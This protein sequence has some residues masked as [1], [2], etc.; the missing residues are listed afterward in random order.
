M[1]SGLFAYGSKIATCPLTSI[2]GILIVLVGVI[3]LW[4]SIGNGVE[5]ENELDK[6]WIEKGGRVQEELDYINKTK[7]DGWTQSTSL[8]LFEAKFSSVATV[9]TSAAMAD[10]LKVLEAV[11]GIVVEVKLEDGSVIPFSFSGYVNEA[12]GKY[13]LCDYVPFPDAIVPSQFSSI[14][15]NYTPCTRVTALDCFREGN[16]DFYLQEYLST[17]QSLN[18]EMIVDQYR[19]LGYDDL[20]SFVGMSNDEIQDA[21][22]DGCE[23]Y[24]RDSMQWDPSLIFGSPKFNS[25]GE[26]TSAQAFQMVVR[27]ASPQQVQTKLPELGLS[28][29]RIEEIQQEWL[30]LLEAK[31]LDLNG[32]LEFLRVEVYAD[33]ALSRVLEEYSSG[34]LLLVSLGYL[35][36]IYFVVFSQFSKRFMNNLILCGLFGVFMVALGNVFSLAVF[37]LLGLKM[38]ATVTQVLPFLALGLGVDDLF[39]FLSVYREVNEN[40]PSMDVKSRIGT[41]L[42]QGGVGIMLTSFCNSVAFGMGALIPI[43]A[44]QI[45]SLASSLAVFV[46]FITLVVSIPA[47]LALQAGMTTP[48]IAP[49]EGPMIVAKEISSSFVTR[50]YIPFLQKK[51]VRI[52]GTILFILVLAVSV[53]LSTMVVNGL[54]ASD[55]VPAESPLARALA[56]RNAHFDSYPSS[57]AT[58]KLDYGDPEI[59]KAMREMVTS[60]KQVDGV[61]I[62][63]SG[64]LDSMINYYCNITND[65]RANCD[66]EGFMDPDSFEDLF[67][68]FVDPTLVTF[69]DAFGYSMQ[70]FG[71]NENGNVTLAL[72]AFDM[73][74][75][76]STSEIVAAIER[77]RGRLS[78]HCGE[79]KVLS[80]CFPNGYVFTLW[81]Q[82]VNL[83]YNF[84]TAFAICEIAVFF[85]CL[86]LVLDPLI[87]LFVSAFSAA[88]VIQIYGGM[89]L[90]DIK[91]SAIP[92]VSLIMSIGIAVEFT[93]H[94]SS[95]FKAA[96]GDRVEKMS[97]AIARMCIPILEG[98]FSSLLGFV[99]LAFS[100][101]D[102]IF[103][104]YFMIYFMVVTVGLING[105]FFLPVIL[106]FIGPKK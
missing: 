75:A 49:E 55:V 106:S 92:A 99:C 13:N 14:V 43:P 69:V 95:H 72:I 29:A 34:S 20:P 90:A 78:E 82:Y 7:T 91:F 32:E 81:E 76:V 21:L 83:V 66:D 4:I 28:S 35:M 102:F 27:L 2:A 19:L 51:T 39:V 22:K 103:K 100:P 38:N 97:E 71:R 33:G 41:V 52:V 37:S 58:G 50:T 36:M 42:K 74:G 85:C 17:L 73:H 62:T 89:Y 31:V 10:Q 65:P 96:E 67:A 11:I 64:W 86:I 23:G 87:A 80:Y 6:L 79:G 26:V 59:Q 93:A 61:R 98:G 56:I 24:I 70:T 84:F 104:Y 47:I 3:G 1:E 57:I 101:F 8:I 63:D 40:H 48:K 9:F 53:I 25:V 5:M 44:I 105:L 46:N 54:D 45:F 94:I 77:V 16:T 30:L 60:L 12:V 15:E 88:T 18:P 68:E